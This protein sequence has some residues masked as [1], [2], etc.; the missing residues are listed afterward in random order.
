[1]EG[2]DGES[3][4]DGGKGKAEKKHTKACK[5]ENQPLRQRREL[6]IQANKNISLDSEGRES[7]IQTKKRINHSGRKK[8]PSW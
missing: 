5:E 3:F 1:M 2:H 6:T 7:T 4:L 8:H